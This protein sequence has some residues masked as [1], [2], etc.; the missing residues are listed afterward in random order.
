MTGGVGVMKEPHYIVFPI[1]P[2]IIGGE[3]CLTEKTIME[4]DCTMSEA[5]E[6]AIS[7]SD[8]WECPMAIVKWK[9]K[10]VW[11]VSIF[12]ENFKPG[13]VKIRL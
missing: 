11:L 10:P 2:S 6:G 12:H 8:Y 7:H 5:I 3:Q 4:I 13:N 9:N 1:T